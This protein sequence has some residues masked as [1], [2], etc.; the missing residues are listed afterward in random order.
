MGGDISR[1]D[2][3]THRCCPGRGRGGWLA[4]LERPRAD[5]GARRASATASSELAVVR[6]MGDI[7]GHDCH[8]LVEWT[9]ARGRKYRYGHDVFGTPVTDEKGGI[10]IETS[11]DNLPRTR[12]DRLTRRLLDTDRDRISHHVSSSQRGTNDLDGDM[13]QNPGGQGSGPE[14]GRQI[15]VG[16]GRPGEGER[17]QHSNSCQSH[18]RRY[19]SPWLH[20]LLLSRHRVTRVIVPPRNVFG[21]RRDAGTGCQP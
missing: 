17:W 3:T 11:S 9:A 20:E 19:Y 21:V 5:H 4:D 12:T 8:A 2:V 18:R 13:Y 15:A 1:S 7:D 16:P 10:S 14:R 6:G